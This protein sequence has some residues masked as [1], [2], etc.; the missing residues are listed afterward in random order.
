M[1]DQTFISEQNPLLREVR[2]SSARGSLTRRGWAIAEGFH[3]LNEA[4]DARCEIG[5]VIAAESVW[6]RLPFDRLPAARWM[7]VT[8]RV[9]GG[10]AS[11]E[12]PQGVVTLVKPPV[13]SLDQMFTGVPLVAVLDGVQDPGNAGAIIRAA[14]SFG[15]TG[16]A[17]LK[18]SA[19]PYNPKC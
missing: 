16:A 6:E 1:P 9:L 14:A 8:D 17:F 5:A 13:W 18:G 12:T 15:A 10:L 19:S 11:A 3:L 2:H 7:K 4:I